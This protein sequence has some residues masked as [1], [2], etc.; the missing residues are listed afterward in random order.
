[1]EHAVRDGVRLAYEEAGRGDPPVMLV[2]GMRGD[3]RHMRAL[4]EHLSTT[5]RVVNVGLRGHGTVTS[6]RRSS[7][8]CRRCSS[9][10]IVRS[11]RRR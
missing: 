8:P 7:A 1:M 6:T 2:H 3:H 4:F 10:R 5:R 9:W 11:P